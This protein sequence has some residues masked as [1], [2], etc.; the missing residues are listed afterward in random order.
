MIGRLP[1]GAMALALVFA[2]MLDAGPAPAAAQPL[3][4]ANSC[5]D[6]HT[7]P[8]IIT[9]LPDPRA[10]MRASVLCLINAERTSRQ[11]PTLSVNTRLTN[12]ADGHAQEAARLRWW[13]PGA[14]SHVHP[15]KDK[16]LIDNPNLTPVQRRSQAIERRI[17]AAGYCSGQPDATGEITYSG[18]GNDPL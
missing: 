1:T 17:V 12:A 18:A 9:D 3:A 16:D 14:D 8:S 15:E 7:P 2:A 11:T 10:R 6:V 13:V 5:P 4:G